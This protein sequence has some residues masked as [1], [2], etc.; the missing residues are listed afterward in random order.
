M[1]KIPRIRI[2]YYDEERAPDVVVVGQWE[3]TL[4]ERKHGKGS[5]R[6]ESIEAVAYQ[7]YQGAKRAGLIT[8]ATDFDTWAREVAVVEAIDEDETD[9]AGEQPGE[10]QAPPGT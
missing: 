5:W 7:A 8:K 2:G 6:G 1:N 10:S 4:A 3:I 9:E